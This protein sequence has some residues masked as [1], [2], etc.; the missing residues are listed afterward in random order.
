MHPLFQKA[1]A[2]SREAIGSAMEVHRPHFQF[3][4]SQTHRRHLPDDFTRS[5]PMNLSQKQT[6][7]TKA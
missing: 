6:K 7:G 2:L 1:D 3:P 4:W 5:K